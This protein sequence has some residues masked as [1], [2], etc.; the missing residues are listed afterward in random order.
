MISVRIKD[1]DF[2]KMK[3]AEYGYTLR[4]YSREIG[5]SHSHL[6]QILNLKSNPSPAV[7]LKISLGMQKEISDFFLIHL[8]DG[9]AGEGR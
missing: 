2:T 6:S 8:V 9:Q 7:A 1:A 3:I 5:I 4:G